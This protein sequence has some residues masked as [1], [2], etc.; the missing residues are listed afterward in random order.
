MVHL[1]LWTKIQMRCTN[2]LIT[3]L[4]FDYDEEGEEEDHTVKSSSAR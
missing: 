3:S 2:V 4:R 1:C